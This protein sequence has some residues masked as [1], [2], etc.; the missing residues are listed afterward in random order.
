MNKRA[1]ELCSALL[2]AALYVT[3]CTSERFDTL[4]CRQAY[5]AVLIFRG[6]AEEHADPPHPLGLLRARRKRQCRR[7]AAEK[8]DERA[9]LHS[10]TSSAISDGGTARPSALAVFA[11]RVVINLVGSCTG[12]SPGFSPLRMRST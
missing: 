8:R 4:E 1:L 7:R 2:I 3:G 12:S 6:R 5:L 10:I 11:F 9:P